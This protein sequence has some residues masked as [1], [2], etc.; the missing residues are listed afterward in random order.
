[1]KNRSGKWALAGLRTGAF[2]LTFLVLAG[3]V[4]AQDDSGPDTAYHEAFLDYKE[5][6]Y[7]AALT[8]ITE[9]E[10]ENPNNVHTEILKARIQTELGQFDDAR[11]T[12]E[13]LTNNPQLIPLEADHVKLAFGDLYLRK[14]SFDEAS[15]FYESL[16]GASRAGDPD[17]ELRLI[18]ARVSAGDNVTAMNYASNL[19]PLDPVN[20]AYYFAKAALAE[21]SNNSAEADEN[22]Q[23]VRTIYGITVANR[24]LKT[25]L[26]VFSPASRGGVNARA[27]PPTTNAPPPSPGQ[28]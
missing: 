13:A 4:F 28:P 8:A 7:D 22:I 6:N 9:A 5:A 17:I 12:L 11:K 25:Y 10:K 1:M 19:K 15:K 18:Y 21:S 2:L 14:R 3:P 20:P 27:A 23:T 16:L 24:Y 26:E